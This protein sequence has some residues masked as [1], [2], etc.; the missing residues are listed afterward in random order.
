MS[1]MSTADVRYADFRALYLAQS[2]A[3]VNYLTRSAIGEIGDWSIIG[4]TTLVRPENLPEE[5]SIFFQRFQKPITELGMSSMII[6]SDVLRDRDLEGLQT[7]LSERWRD[8]N[9]RLRVRSA[10]RSSPG[11][12]GP[13][14]PSPALH[15]DSL[16]E[17]D[18]IFLEFET[19][20]PGHGCTCGAAIDGSGS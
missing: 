10:A 12:R 13:G 15:S 3:I 8:E 9:P 6:L 20:D 14:Y 1:P 11:A 18:R 4:K 7:V 5:V 2:C 19:N 17:H 16:S